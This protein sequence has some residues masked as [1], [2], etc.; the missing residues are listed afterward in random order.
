M[1][2]Y[3]MNT[4]KLIFIIQLTLNIFLM[5]NADAAEKIKIYNAEKGAIEEV[6]RIAK[7]DD[8]WRKILTPE[9]FDITRKKGTERPFTKCDFPK[10]EGIYRCVCCGTD[11]FTA[12]KK[13]D[14]GTGWPSFWQPVSKLN[15]KTKPDISMFEIRTEVLCARCAAHLGHVFSDGP[16]PTYK[17]YCINGEALKFYEKEQ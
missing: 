14:S 8:E 13:F 16:P 17:R 9:Q 4:L 5:T 11:L 3:S 7:T 10:E 15:I 2:H 12:D 1:K 6:E